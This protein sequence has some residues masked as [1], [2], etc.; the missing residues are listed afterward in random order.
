MT[1][2]RRDLDSFSR[3][4]EALQPYL[5]DL[6]F[7]GGWAHYLYTLRP[8]A[9][10]LSFEPL[11]TEDADIAAPARLSLGKETIAE[12][13][14]RADF[15]ERLSSEYTPP[16]SEYVLGD[17][18]TGFYLEFLAALVGGEIKRGGRDVTTMVAGVTAQTLR[19]LDLLL[20]APWPLTL[21]RDGG[22]SVARPRTIFIANPAA[23]VVQKMLVLQKRPPG[24]AG[25][26]SPLRS[27][28]L[29]DPRGLARL[30]EGSLGSATE[31]H[32]RRPCSRQPEGR[33]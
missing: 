5:K 26:G 24:Q 25:Q 32:A 1:D 14:T 13:L 8:E 18:K 3:A 10:P 15:R 20:T 4:V 12:R 33:A 11:L 28:H 27:R 2:D 23:Y 7:V 21:T 31:D 9:G 30:R 19:Y 16:I 22:F 29:R 17:E 6:V